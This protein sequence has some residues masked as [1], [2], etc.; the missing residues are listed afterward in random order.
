MIHSAHSVST[1]LAR[2]FFVSILF[3]GMAWSDSS[4][5]VAL[6]WMPNTNHVGLYVANEKGF[7]K[8]AGLEVKILPY[9]D[10]ASGVLVSNQRADFGVS[11]VGYYSL[12]AA[13]SD[14]QAVYG[15][16]QKDT[17][18]LVVDSK[19][20]DIHSP[21]DLDGKTYGGFGSAWE[22]T[23][24]T[25]IIQHDGGKGQFRSVTLGSSAYQALSSGSVDFTLEIIT[26]EGVEA[27]LQGEKLKAFKYSEYGVPEQQTTLL[28]SN[29]GWL[30]THPDTARAF[31]AA[32]DKGYRYAVAHPEEAAQL[33]LNA[34]PTT[35]TNKPLV[36]KSLA[37]LVNDHYFQTP[38]GVTGRLDPVKAQ[39]IGHYLF[40][41][42]ILKDENG[43]TLQQEPDFTQWVTNDYLPQATSQ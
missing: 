39:A 20:N 17:G 24:L 41:H 33:L 15:V 35:L 11:G 29:P 19:R 9:S 25:S 42:Q 13:G 4:V 36:E 40:S 30:K 43:K 37:L 10:T 26:W 31:L 21:K 7:Y 1:A 14:L 12:R 2:F 34:N 27:Q 18:R 28:V 5:T 8:Q 38:E 3:S 32:T 6:D 22:Q 23:L 16:V